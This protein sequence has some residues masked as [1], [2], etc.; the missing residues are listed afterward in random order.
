MS[1]SP[2][3]MSNVHPE[4]AARFDGLERTLDPISIGHLERV[5][6]C[7]WGPLPGDR[8]RWWFHR[9]M[10]RLA[11]GPDGHVVAV[12]LDTRWFRHDG[13]PQLEVRR[14]TW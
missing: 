7:R 12:D 1:D 11:V 5:G 9:S 6:V 13:S 10:A 8:D 4:T 3:L 14:S 2:Y